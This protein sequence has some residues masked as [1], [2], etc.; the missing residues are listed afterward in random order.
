MPH[1]RGLVDLPIILEIHR[2]FLQSNSGFVVVGGSRR[3]T[4]LKAVTA[5]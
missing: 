2:S 1:Q 5:I 4:G 3:T